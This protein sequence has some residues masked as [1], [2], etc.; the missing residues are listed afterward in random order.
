MTEGSESNGKR[1]GND[2]EVTWPAGANLEGTYSCEFSYKMK[3]KLSPGNRIKVL[4]NSRI[5]C[6][7]VFKFD[8][9]TFL[10]GGKSLMLRW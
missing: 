8:F 3:D 9:G 2:L 1:N 5:R 4:G 6:W 7:Q 10:F